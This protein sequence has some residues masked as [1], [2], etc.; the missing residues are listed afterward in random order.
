MKY[1]VLFLY[2]AQ[3]DM[4]TDEEKKTFIEEFQNTDI[5]LMNEKTMENLNK[6]DTDGT[7][8]PFIFFI[9]KSY[10]C[11]PCQRLSMPIKIFHNKNAKTGANIEIRKSILDLF[12]EELNKLFKN[13]KNIHD[14]KSHR[15]VLV[16]IIYRE[17]SSHFINELTRYL[18]TI[19][20]FPS[21][22]LV[23]RQKNCDTCKNNTNS[24]FSVIDTWI[25]IDNNL[26]MWKNKIIKEILEKLKSHQYIDKNEK[27]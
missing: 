5:V 13:Y 11:P 15:K 27:K 7:L 12:T 26:E 1:F 16:F 3:S 24:M 14:H 19:T 8:F 9:F 2:F 10:E 17:E 20:A 18:P 23:C 6:V 21:F 25:G 4:I 22:F